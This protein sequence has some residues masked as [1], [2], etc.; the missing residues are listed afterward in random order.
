MKAISDKNKIEVLNCFELEAPMT[1]KE[2]A[3]KLNLPYSRINYHIK[4]LEKVGIIEVVD[5]KIKQGIIEKYYLPTAEEFRIDKS[6][7]VFEN[8]KDLDEYK[9]QIKKFYDS[10]FKNIGEDYKAWVQNITPEKP[11]EG[12]M[13]CSAIFLNEEQAKDL[14]EDIER[15]FKSILDKYG[16]KKEGTKA[17]NVGSFLIVKKNQSVYFDDL[18]E[19][20]QTEK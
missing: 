4:L 8:T 5:T 2:I 7:C 9:K 1:V 15:Y 3:E 6:I 20:E 19:A 17:Y 10:I 14:K 18:E 11:N 12:A 13:F 16:D